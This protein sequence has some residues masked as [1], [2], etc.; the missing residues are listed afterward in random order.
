MVAGVGTN[1]LSGTL[2]N[3]RLLQD[4]AQPFFSL[5]LVYSG[6]DLVAAKLDG[7]DIPIQI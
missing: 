1:S 5:K 2:A 6:D 4:A 7:R 3:L